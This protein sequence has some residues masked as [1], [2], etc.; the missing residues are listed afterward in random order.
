MP[1]D[2]I[3][4]GLRMCNERSKMGA[5][6]PFRWEC[7]MERLGLHALSKP[8]LCFSVVIE[9]ICSDHKSTLVTE[10]VC[11]CSHALT[12][13]HY[14]HGILD[15]SVTQPLWITGRVTNRRKQWRTVYSPFWSSSPKSDS[16]CDG[17]AISLLTRLFLYKLYM[18]LLL[19][20]IPEYVFG[21]LYL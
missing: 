13:C 7:Y 15:V 9:R 17:L 6:A 11:S 14:P 8:S 20:N 10:W 21:T 3:R 5:W 1:L 16:W 19:R 12:P 4:G 2:F 18:N